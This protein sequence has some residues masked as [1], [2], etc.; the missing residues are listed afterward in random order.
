[1]H[2]VAHPGHGRRSSLYTDYTFGLETR[3]FPS[4]EPRGWF[5]GGGPQLHLI[6]LAAGSGGQTFGEASTQEIGA[7]VILGYAL[8][9]GESGLNLEG[10]GSYV[11]GFNS[12][13]LMVGYRFGRWKANPLE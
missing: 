11:S 10:R 3:H 13:Q 6:D 5:Y 12:V 4:G 1:M 7:T 2:R 8:G 9:G